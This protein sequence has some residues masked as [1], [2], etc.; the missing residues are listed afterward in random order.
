MAVLSAEKF[1]FTFYIQGGTYRTYIPVQIFVQYIPYN[2]I[3][4]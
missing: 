1:V 2:G 3:V 4:D